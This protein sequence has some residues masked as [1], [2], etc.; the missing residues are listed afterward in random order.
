MPR[1]YVVVPTTSEVMSPS[2]VRIWLPGSLGSESEVQGAVAGLAY[3]ATPEGGLELG[4]EGVESVSLE[5]IQAILC[6]PSA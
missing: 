2:L 3:T 1:R 4:S 5:F 6:T